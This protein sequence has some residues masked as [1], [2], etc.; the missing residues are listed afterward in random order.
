LKFS[1]TVTTGTNGHDW[2]FEFIVWSEIGSYFTQ[3]V[4]AYQ[5]LEDSNG[6]S[7]TF[8]ID[9]SALKGNHYIGFAIN[10]N[11]GQKVIVNKIW[12]E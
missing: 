1:G 9:I 7:G 6:V 4:A 2:W 11:G 5:C 8:T 10:G 3:N 12:L